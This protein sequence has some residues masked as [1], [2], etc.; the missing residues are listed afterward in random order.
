MLCL[1]IGWKKAEKKQQSI[2][3]LVYSSATS[4]PRSMVAGATSA[5]AAAAQSTAGRSHV[6][7]SRDIKLKQTRTGSCG[8][9]LA[10]VGVIARLCS[11][12]LRGAMWC[13]AC[14]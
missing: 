14:A 10:V 2:S 5:A 7:E 8:G 4:L 9:R 12:G 6:R 11:P 1:F 3:L 13:L